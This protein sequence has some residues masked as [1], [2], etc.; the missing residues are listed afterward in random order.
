[1]EVNLFYN[2]FSDY[3]PVTG[4]YI[5]SDPIGLQGRLNTYGYVSG[6]SLSFI[7]PK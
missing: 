7:D 2:H 1:M 5:E 6:N 4:R 3:D